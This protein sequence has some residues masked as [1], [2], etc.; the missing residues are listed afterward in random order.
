MHERFEKRIEEGLE[1]IVASCGKR[2]Q[3]PAAVGQRVGRLWART[4]ERRQRLRSR[5]IQMQTALQSAAGK[6][7]TLAGVGTTQR[8]LL[9]VAQQ[10]DGLEPGRS[11]AGLHPADRGRGRVSHSEDGSA[12][13]TG[14]AP[15]TRAGGGAHPGLLS[16]LCVVEDAGATLPTRWVGQRTAESIRGIVG[17]D[18]GRCRVTN[19]QRSNDSKAL[20]QPTDRAPSDPVATAESTSPQLAGNGPSVVKTRP[21]RVENTA[22]YSS[23]CGTWASTVNGD[24]QSGFSQQLMATS[25]NYCDG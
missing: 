5:S 12:T 22:I 17:H 13:A 21:V 2:K 14:L 3:L 4:H 10:R 25:V 16:G 24:N 11:L 6:D 23:N 8:G 1:K 15:E 9:R 20:R 19:S 7:R 18:A